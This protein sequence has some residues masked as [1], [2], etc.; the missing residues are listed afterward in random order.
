LPAVVAALGREDTLDAAMAEAITSSL[1]SRSDAA[2]TWDL[3]T[4]TY[5]KY[6]IGWTEAG[7]AHHR[8]RAYA[9]AEKCFLR[10]VELSDRNWY[11]V[12]SLAD[13]YSDITDRTSSRGS[14]A[15]RLARWESHD[16]SLPLYKTA[17][18]INPIDFRTLREHAMLLHLV[19]EMSLEDTLSELERSLA[20]SR[21]RNQRAIVLMVWICSPERAGQVAL[22]RRIYE[23]HRETLTDPSVASAMLDPLM[24]TMLGKWRYSQEEAMAWGKRNPEEA[25]VLAELLMKALQEEP[26]WTNRHVQWAIFT[27]LQIIDSAEIGLEG[28]APLEA[29]APSIQGGNSHET[30]YMYLCAGVLLARSQRWEAASFCLGE[31]EKGPEMTF[32]QRAGG[33]RFRCLAHLRQPE[34]SKRVFA[35][36]MAEPERFDRKW[37]T[38]QFYSNL[39]W[40]SDEDRRMARAKLMEADIK[41]PHDWYKFHIE[42]YSVELGE[43]D[44]ARASFVKRMKKQDQLQAAEA[45]LWAAICESLKQDAAW[46]PTATSAADNP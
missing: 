12:A 5:P 6:Q 1:R 27:A 45:A 37:I 36:I 3:V 41:E 28:T 22:G 14:E 26:D 13:H 43:A 32:T 38:N 34:E 4:R 15:D 2:A 44:V 46:P 21:D 9:T 29:L 18:R 39:H 17:L 10:A 24:D 42:H 23:R 30:Q 25:R 11:A 35:R 7:W 19:G 16:L 20:L 31:A 33:W 8:M 40:A